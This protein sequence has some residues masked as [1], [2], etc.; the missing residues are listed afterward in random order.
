MNANRYRDLITDLWNV[1]NT[2]LDPPYD[3]EAEEE[4]TELLFEGTRKYEN[5]DLQE[6]KRDLVDAFLKEYKRLKRVRE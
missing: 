5:T 1:L 4:I 3:D 2:Y 6:F